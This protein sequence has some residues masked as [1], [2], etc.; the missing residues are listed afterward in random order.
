MMIT[1][2]IADIITRIRNG[3]QAMMLSV[4][5]PAS[6]MKIAIVDILKREG[7]IKGYKVVEDGKQGVLQLTLKYY[8]G[9]P[10][11]S[12]IERISKPG[13]RVYSGASDIPRV[14]DGLGIVIVS[15]SKGV[16]TDRSARAKMAGGE[17]L[18]RVW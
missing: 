1:D 13:R 11:I 3:G 14:R 17:V 2:P 18:L 8:N 6:K 15:T 4:D 10:V 16:M 9:K 12:G 5:V 7:Y